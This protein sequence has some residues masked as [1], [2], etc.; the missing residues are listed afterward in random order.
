MKRTSAS[1]RGGGDVCGCLLTKGIMP[2]Y[3][4]VYASFVRVDILTRAREEARVL[5]CSRRIESA[6]LIFKFIRG[7]LEDV[8]FTLKEGP[9][10]LQLILLSKLIL[11]IKSR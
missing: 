11:Y 9:I 5:G 4:F 7:I 10:L 1:L 2:A 3:S 8:R 6:A